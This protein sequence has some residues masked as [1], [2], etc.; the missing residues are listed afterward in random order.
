MMHNFE[1]CKCI[2]SSHFSLNSQ[3]NHLLIKRMLASLGVCRVLPTLIVADIQ[4]IVSQTAICG[5]CSLV[6]VKDVIVLKIVFRWVWQIFK[7]CSDTY[8]KSLLSP[9]CTQLTWKRGMLFL[10]CRD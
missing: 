1:C 4:V 6:Q 2:I 7:E 3:V 10:T 9:L 8:L 5:I